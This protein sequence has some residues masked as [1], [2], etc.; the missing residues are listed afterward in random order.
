MEE[1]EISISF[2]I[3]YSREE[4]RSIVDILQFKFGIKPAEEISSYRYLGPIPPPFLIIIILV[5]ISLE[6]FLGGFFDESGRILARR[7]FSALKRNKR[8]EFLT[9]RIVIKHRKEQKKL[10][11]TAMDAGELQSKIKE[12]LINNKRRKRGRGEIK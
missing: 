7:L 5:A 12:L 4:R 10:D 1:K 8:I 6:S 11:I 3:R 2:D 9:L